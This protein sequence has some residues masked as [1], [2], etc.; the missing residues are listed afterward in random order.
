MPIDRLG[1]ELQQQAPPVTLPKFVFREPDIESEAKEVAARLLE[2]K[3]I[4]AG[5]DAW[6]TIGKAECFE[7]WKVIGAAL[8][9][10]KAHA[11]RVTGANRAWG[12]HYSRECAKLHHFRH[13]RCHLWLQRWL[14][15]VLYEQLP[16]VCYRV[17]SMPN[18]YSSLPC[19]R[20][21]RC[22]RRPALPRIGS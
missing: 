5:L 18:H 11:L 8:S 1:G 13:S 20:A 3:T 9:I 12:Q 4:R 15:A 16:S 10:G 19:R 17:H 7:S 21:P 6:K 14:Q 2:R 22:L